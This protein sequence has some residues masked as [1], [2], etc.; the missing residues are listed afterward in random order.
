ME[1]IR[2]EGK[3]KEENNCVKYSHP[4]DISFIN[5]GDYE[6]F[7]HGGYYEWFFHGGD[8]EE[9][10]HDD[11]YAWFSHGGYYEWFFSWR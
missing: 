3:R 11:Y 5:C 2:G 6:D 7:L 1:E 9:Y 4:R 10:F 8:Y